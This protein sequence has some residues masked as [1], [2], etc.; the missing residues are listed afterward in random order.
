MVTF[1]F[2]YGFL[3]IIGKF[4]GWLVIRRWKC[5]KEWCVW[6]CFFVYIVTLVTAL[7]QSVVHGQ[8]G[9]G[10][11][12]PVVWNEAPQTHLTG[13]ANVNSLAAGRQ[14]TFDD[15]WF[16]SEMNARSWPANV[17]NVPTC[18]FTFVKGL[19]FFTLTPNYHKTLIRNQRPATIHL[20]PE[21]LP[22]NYQRILFTDV[23]KISNELHNDFTTFLKFLAILTGSRIV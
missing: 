21:P 17:W 16:L 12:W 23:L 4:S 11:C 8:R 13:Y 3:W 20:S 5:L 6:E 2:S 15:A 10:G 22:F 18:W 7:Y 19:I 14:I 9:K 1:E